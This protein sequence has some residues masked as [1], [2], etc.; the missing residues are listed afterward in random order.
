MT[1]LIVLLILSPVLVGLLVLCL[2]S[3]LKFALPAYA[4]LMPFGGLL[5]VG[6]S[7]FG[8]SSSLIGIVLGIGLVFQLLATTR[9]GVRISATIP[10]WLLFL[11]VAGATELW[12]VNPAQTATGFL[13]LSSLVLIYVLV[14]INNVDRAVLNRTEN[15]LLIGGV[16]A[17]CYGFTQLLFLGGFPQDPSVSSSHQAGRFGNDMLGP[18]NEAVALL[19][20]L[21]VALSRSLTLPDRSKRILHGFLAL[22]LF[23]GIVMTG[24]RGGILATLTAVIVLA[25]SNPQGRRTLI[26]G[27][28]AGVV[29]V[30]L[31]WVYHPAGIADR[32]VATTSSS[33][34]TDIWRVGI[35]AC[36][37]YCARGAG[38][39][40]FPDVYAATQA[41]VPDAAVLV[42]GGN[43]QPHNVWLLVAIE[44]GL[45]GLVLLASVL[46]V[47]FYE[48][49]RLPAALRGPPM[50]GFIA[51]I[52]AA[53]FLSNL[54]YKFFWMA[55][56]LVA[57]SR[58]VALGESRRASGSA[59]TSH[60]GAF[61]GGPAQ[62]GAGS[63]SL[64]AGV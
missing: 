4:A 13:I 27:L 49:L 48:A 37:H 34:R 6:T 42:G 17:T 59:G 21:L 62:P 47:T 3:P 11:A 40:T 57:L 26:K 50:S 30:A 20:P 1:K 56:I 36:P 39:E 2:R 23:V 16:L 55:L 24:S 45:P 10:I 15:G 52:V 12:S 7:R 44:L 19:L 43:Y 33:G 8:S 32:S 25:M 58:N 35:A 38:W 60:V 28:A 64:P 14:G 5:S 46:I 29:L 63:V 41:S 53:L 54:E 22:V 31:A 18:N 51:T 61:G 9:P